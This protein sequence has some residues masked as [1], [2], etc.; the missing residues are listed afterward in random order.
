MNCDD[1]K[2][3]CDWCPKKFNSIEAFQM[4]T[5]SKHLEKVQCETCEGWFFQEGSLRFHQQTKH[6]ASVKVI[7]KHMYLCHICG[8][9]CS[10]LSLH[11]YKCHQK[12]MERVYNCNECGFFFLDR[13]F[14]LLHIAHF[15]STWICKDCG[16]M[17]ETR[18]QLREHM[19]LLEQ[20]IHE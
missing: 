6:K 13:L 10:D 4:H 12:K 19:G 11:I 17:F 18:N 15:H 2:I 3:A 7:K 1:K 8:S 5:K 9:L 16:H 14:F 20:T